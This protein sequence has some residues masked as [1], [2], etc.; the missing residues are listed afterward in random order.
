MSAE[1]AVRRALWR[2]TVW[3]LVGDIISLP[4]RVFEAFGEWLEQIELAVFY[5]ELDAARRYALLTG[6]DLGTAVGQ[7]RRYEGLKQ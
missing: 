7:E 6:I 4:R 2:V 1:R 5:L 3:R